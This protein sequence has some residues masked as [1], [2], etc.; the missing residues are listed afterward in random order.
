[1]AVSKAELAF[2][3]LL[4]VA[5]H[6]AEVLNAALGLRRRVNVDRFAIAAA[7]FDLL[8]AADASQLLGDGFRAC[9]ALGKGLQSCG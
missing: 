5:G 4:D 2:S 8:A 3:G 9:S 1:V 6:Q 7:T